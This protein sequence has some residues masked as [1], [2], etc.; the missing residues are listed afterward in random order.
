MR[1]SAI[2]PERWSMA[3]SPSAKPARVRGCCQRPSSHAGAIRID[4]SAVS[5]VRKTG[6]H[7]S[8]RCL[9][10]AP[11]TDSLTLE[12]A[13]LDVDVLTGIYSDETGKPQ[14]FRLSITAR[15]IGKASCRERGC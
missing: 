5:L 1:C 4:L 8:A 7:F 14:P 9:L 3:S 12:V 11:M 2:C 15:Q 13:D 10:G 6:S